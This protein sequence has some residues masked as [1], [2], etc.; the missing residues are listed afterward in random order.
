MLLDV[1]H[2][3][4]VV[5][6]PEVEPHESI[7]IFVRS[8]VMARVY[9][10]ISPRMNFN[11]SRPSLWWW[12][13]KYW[14]LFN[15]YFFSACGSLPK[16]SKRRKKISACPWLISNLTPRVKLAGYLGYSEVIIQLYK[17]YGWLDL[18][19]SLGLPLVGCLLISPRIKFTAS[20]TSLWWRMWSS[21][22]LFNLCFFSACGLPPIWLISNLTC[23]VKLP[24][25]LGLS[26]DYGIALQALGL[27]WLIIVFKLAFCGVFP[28]WWCLKY[29]ILQEWTE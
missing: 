5:W 18:L 1:N 19:L 29:F 23:R 15:L 9:L 12:N 2:A 22:I 27:T 11:A 7:G 4:W 26:W 17:H 10:L 13:E 25:Y 14:N 16:N 28:T 21:G 6:D 8:K 3:R 20:R 24:G